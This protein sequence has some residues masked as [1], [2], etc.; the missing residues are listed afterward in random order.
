[1]HSDL[2]VVRHISA[3]A[4]TAHIFRISHFFLYEILG[5]HNR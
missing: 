3:V 1:M 2:T 4:G 5:S